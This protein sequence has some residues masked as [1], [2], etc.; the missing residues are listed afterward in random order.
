M[1]GGVR[2]V[3]PVFIPLSD[4]VTLAARLWLPAGGAP[5]PAILE[6]VP[7]R[8]NDGTFLI[9]HPRYSW[10]AEHGYAGVRVDL[11]GSGDSEGLITDEYLRQEQDDT[12]EVLAWLAGQAWCSGQVAM[13][14]F[15]WG[16]FAGLQVA[17]RRPPELAAVVT[18]NS[19]VRRYTD[20]CHYTG[21]MV[22][23]HD[24]LSWATTMYA[25]DARPPDP[26]VVGERWRQMWADR[27]AVPPMVDHWLA[28][29]LED[30]YWRH[31]SVCFDYSKL[32]APILA[33]GGWA[34]PYRNAVLDL[35]RERPDLCRGIVGPWAHGYPQ[36]TLPGPTIDFL[37]ECLRFFDRHVHPQ[38]TAGDVPP[39]RLYVQDF[40]HHSDDRRERAGRWMAVADMGS[41]DH[42]I[43]LGAGRVSVDERCGV[44]A[45]AW[46]PY[47]PAA[48][49]GD[50]RL[51]DELSWCVD[52]EP[53][54]SAVEIA[55][56]AV[57]SMRVSS[58]RAMGA[59]IVRLCDVAPDGA[60]VLVARGVLN[61]SHRDGHDHLA[62]VE[63]NE[64][65]DVTLRLDA[66]AHRF[67]EGHR[68]R[69]AVSASYWPWIWPL[70]ERFTLTA[71]GGECVL[72]LLRADTEPCDLGSAQ[73]GDEAEVLRI[74]PRITARQ[75]DF[76]LGRLR[77]AD[78]DVEVE[79]GGD[80][81]YSTHTDPL[82]AVVR[83]VRRLAVSRPGWDTRVEVDSRM[84]CTADEFHVT[85]ELSAWDNDVEV[86][87]SVHHTTAPRRGC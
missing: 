14:G 3:D 74:E 5:V 82:D 31:G 26:A 7:Y 42:V 75:P 37:G 4:G 87:R 45:G 57:L 59:V 64:V 27:L 55:G 13:I 83:V 40:Q 66:A 24:M 32:C 8:R 10:W 34:D 16:G 62:A 35:V 81:D 47:G 68:L 49:P 79:E 48:T 20:D 86:H 80:N 6:A 60:S 19:V 56:F 72:P 78:L 43:D 71:H 44:A 69:L 84:W 38:R 85:S 18:V 61:L 12:L 52:S 77:I 33:V 41:A 76:L 73:W 15:S 9:D 1:T 53:L 29:Q 23:A 30:D 51:D 54:S 46:C 17:A 25:F 2:L 67:A 58:D 63:P 50:Q 70:P 22:N 21:G 11:R 36:A 28:H 65:Y 39:L